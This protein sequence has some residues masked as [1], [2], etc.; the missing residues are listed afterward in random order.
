MTDFKDAG[1]L[2]CNNR[3]II[4]VHWFGTVGIVLVQ[5]NLT[6]EYVSYIKDIHK[7]NGPRVGLPETSDYQDDILN[8]MA[9]GNKFPLEA[10]KVLFDNIEMKNEAWSTTHP[11]FFL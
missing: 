7:S 11:E 8:I 9:Y 3:T 2:D 10:A 1:K 6:F 5:D 4:G